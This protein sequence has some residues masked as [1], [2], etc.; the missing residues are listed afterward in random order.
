MIILRIPR[1]ADDKD[2]REFILNQIKK[3]RRN[4]RHKYIKLRGEIA[5][6][7][8]YVYFV[9]E[10]Y[11]L[12]LAFA[13]SILLKCQRQEIPCSLE[14]S[15]PIRVEELSQEVVKCADRW[16]EGKLWRRCYKLKNLNV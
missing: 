1:R 11:G 6:S 2:L 15:K 14:R 10:P 3:F 8:D 13:L 16:S 12:E 7:T 4:Q 9:L 5:Y